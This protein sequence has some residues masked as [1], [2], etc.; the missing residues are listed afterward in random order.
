MGTDA[1]I[2]PIPRG[3]L[4]CAASFNRRNTPPAPPFSIAVN[5]RLFGG[6]KCIEIAWKW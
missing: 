6:R 2:L 3:V 1:P 5:K 4:L